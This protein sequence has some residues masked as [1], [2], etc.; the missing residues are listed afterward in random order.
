[1]AQVAEIA[2]AT[3]RLRAGAVVF[4]AGIEFAPEIFDDESAKK[5]ITDGVGDFY[6]IIDGVSSTLKIL[7]PLLG[8]AGIERPEV[9]KTDLE[10]G[11]PVALE[12]G[13]ARPPIY[14]AAVP[15]ERPPADAEARPKD[16]IER[17]T[18]PKNKVKLVVPSVADYLKAPDDALALRVDTDNATLSIGDSTLVISSKGAIKA[19]NGLFGLERGKYMAKAEF[20]DAF[21]GRE[22]I[23]SDLARILKNLQKG[24]EISFDHPL[25]EVI[26][27]RAGAKYRLNP[28]LYPVDANRINPPPNTDPKV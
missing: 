23:P 14:A 1:V 12:A 2:E 16:S 6:E 4:E 5:T 8:L 7:A 18:D 19:L 10:G 24:F 13:E 26:S 17:D 27:K 22:N 28:I 9:I 15:T 3:R 20:A 21:G 25:W 11:S